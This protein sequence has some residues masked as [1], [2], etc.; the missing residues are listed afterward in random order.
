MLPVLFLDT[1]WASEVLP[2]AF[3]LTKRFQRRRRWLICDLGMTVCITA[4]VVLLIVLLLQF[5]GFRCCLS[6][7]EDFQ[8]LCSF[9]GLHEFGMNMYEHHLWKVQL[10]EHESAK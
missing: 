4:T 6:I 7:F 8:A 9:L 2:L 5:L 1:P 3:A 10:L